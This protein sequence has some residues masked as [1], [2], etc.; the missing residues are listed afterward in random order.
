MSND[1]IATLEPELGPTGK[2][3]VSA[4]LYDSTCDAISRIEY[5]ARQ[6]FPLASVVKVAIAMKYET[7]VFYGNLSPQEAV[8]IFRGTSSPGPALNPLDRLFFIP[9]TV[10]KSATL[11]QLHEMMLTS[12]DQHGR[13]RATSA[14][15]RYRRHLSLPRLRE[16]TIFTSA[17]R[18][19]NCCSTITD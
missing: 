16:S 2:L 13:R 12:S 17:A 4:C 8:P 9:W 1:V 15:R 19:T 7:D 5:K 14:R 3:G 11:E 6:F 10:E 18:S